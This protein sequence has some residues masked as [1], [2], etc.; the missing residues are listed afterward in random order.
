[1]LC[2]FFQFLST[3]LR[4]LTTNVKNLENFSFKNRKTFFVK[5]SVQLGL[6]S[7]KTRQ[8]SIEFIKTKAYLRSYCLI[9]TL[10]VLKGLPH[11]IWN[12]TRPL[13]AWQGKRSKGVGRSPT[14]R[15]PSMFK[16]PF[17]TGRKTQHCSNMTNISEKYQIMYFSAKNNSCL[18]HG[19]IA[20]IKRT[21]NFYMKYDSTMFQWS[22]WITPSK[23][24]LRKV[25]FVWINFPGKSMKKLNNNNTC[26]NKE[27]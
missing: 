23:N 14:F 3:V 24:Q 6:I 9:Y 17:F 20:S 1:M 13:G 12:L 19:W 8:E 10:S 4:K 2:F 25:H 27:L 16:H 22:C 15:P 11:N 7:A 5:T 18:K 26:K 21:S